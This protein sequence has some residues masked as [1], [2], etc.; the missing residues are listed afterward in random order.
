M[1]TTNCQFANGSQHLVTHGKSPALSDATQTREAEGLEDVAFLLARSGHAGKCMFGGKRWT[2][3]SSNSL[4][5]IAFGEADER[6][7][8]DSSDLAACYRTVMR[9]P[10]HR[11]TDAVFDHLEAGER[12]VESKYEGSIKWAREDTG[13]PGRATLSAGSAGQ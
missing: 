5:S 7:P 12:H 9:L 6:L 8:S 1:R 4:V 3:M 11:R 10:K 13:W 2:G